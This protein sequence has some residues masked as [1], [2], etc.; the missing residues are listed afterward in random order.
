MK[1][2]DQMRLSG[3]TQLETMLLART[4]D[5]GGRNR[6][7]G[8]VLLFT[9]ELSE[10]GFV[11]VATFSPAFDTPFL[12]ENPSQQSRPR[13]GDLSAALFARLCRSGWRS[14][15]SAASPSSAPTELDPSHRVSQVPR[16]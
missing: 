3:E 13:S 1:G 7:A 16:P 14:N 2:T 11:L 9:S 5:A 4:Q 6:K 10:H 15:S 8:T 12:A